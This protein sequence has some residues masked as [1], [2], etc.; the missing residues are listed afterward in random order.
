MEYEDD[1][2]FVVRRTPKDRR[3]TEHVRDMN[4]HSRKLELIEQDG[5]GVAVGR[6][7]GRK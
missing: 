3:I 4:T 7:R 2:Y 5:L 1:P 6:G